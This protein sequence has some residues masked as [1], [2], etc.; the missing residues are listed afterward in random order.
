MRT[1]PGVIICTFF[2][3]INECLDDGLNEC[4][5]NCTNT[6][7]SYNCSCLPGYRL[8]NNTICTDVDECM[9]RS[10]TCHANATCINM[11]G[12]FS[13]DCNSGYTGDGRN[14]T[15]M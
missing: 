1:R 8:V 15:G 7:A 5:H 11:I 9:E 2:S 14:C 6:E 12:S 10:D 4:D 3:D 13:C